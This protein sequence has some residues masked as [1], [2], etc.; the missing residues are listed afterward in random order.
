MGLFGGSPKKS[1]FS[2]TEGELN[3]LDNA[4]QSQDMA[5]SIFASAGHQSQV[6]NA[7]TGVGQAVAQQSSNNAAMTAGYNVNNADDMALSMLL[8]NNNSV[9]K[10]NFAGLGANMA[11][12]AGAHSDMMDMNQQKMMLEQQEQNR[13]NKERADKRSRRMDALGVV[14]GYGVGIGD[15]FLAGRDW[16]SG[17]V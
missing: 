2:A 1:Q 7:R 8:G 10:D 4:R 11:F 14:S 17:L 6:D 5:N 3:L 16:H 12:G 13:K 9:A 15:N